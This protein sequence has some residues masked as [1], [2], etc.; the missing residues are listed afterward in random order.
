MSLLG[1]TYGSDERKLVRRSSRPRKFFRPHFGP[2]MELPTT[3]LL[4]W[5]KES[6]TVFGVTVQQPEVTTCNF[7]APIATFG[8]L[9]DCQ[10]ALLHP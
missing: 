6:R 10:E 9:S 2:W 4:R 8:A 5:P 1:G 3:K 7:T